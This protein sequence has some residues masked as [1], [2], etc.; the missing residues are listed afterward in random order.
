V[1]VA[2][3]VNPYASSVNE[4]RRRLAHDGLADDHDLTVYE[5]T[6]RDHATTLAAE[7][8]AAGAEVVV[9]L[10]GDGTLNEAAN[11][12]VGTDAALAPLPGGSTNVFARTLGIP[13]DVGKAVRQ[14]RSTLAAGTIRRMP[15]GVVNGRYFLFHVGLGF[16]AAVVE[17]VE[18]R[19][20]LKHRLGQAAFV[21][22]T[23]TTLARHFD[24]RR[25][26]FTM[27][28]GGDPATGAPETNVDG[29]Y[30]VVMNSN[31]YTYL[32]R[33]ALN[34]TD[35][36]QPGRGLVAV[37]VRTMHLPAVVG[38]LTSAMGSGKRLRRNAQVD[39]RPDLHSF[40]VTGSSPFPYQADGD[41]LG[42]AEKL[43]ISYEP[44][45]LAIVGPSPARVT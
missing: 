13:N 17:Q 27:R 24:L 34:L 43:S 4:K 3:V 11:G 5:T 20:G 25:S 6:C 26:H 41:Y 29:A 37:T 32:G 22:A 44:D 33:I 14:L 42:L 2:L 1:K 8:A 38:L 23:V 16:D 10:G 31:P 36:A 15:L 19:P 7:A 12:L 28:F 18:R 45:A 39:H 40:T 35:A 30:A 21:Y 9:V